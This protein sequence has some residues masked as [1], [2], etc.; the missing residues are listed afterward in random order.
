M[1]CEYF[2]SVPAVT[3]SQVKFNL[4]CFCML[5]PLLPLVVNYSIRFITFSAQ[6]GPWRVGKG[7]DSMIYLSSRDS[8]AQA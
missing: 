1:C 8:K 7:A 6:Y 5:S 2:I 4:Q 3:F